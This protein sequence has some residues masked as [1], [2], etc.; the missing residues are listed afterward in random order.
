MAVDRDP[1]LPVGDKFGL[2]ALAWRHLA[3]RPGFGV[4]AAIGDLVAGDI[5]PGEAEGFADPGCAPALE[6]PEGPVSRG[7]GG[8]KQGLELLRGERS[9]FAMAVDLHESSRCIASE[10]K[11]LLDLV[12]VR[13]GKKSNFRGLAWFFPDAIWIPHLVDS[14]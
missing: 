9:G 10:C 11:Q 4:S 1:G 7:R 8:S 2:E 14:Q 6:S 5:S 3:G 13:F 12:W